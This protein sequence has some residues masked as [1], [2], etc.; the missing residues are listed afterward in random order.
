[1]TIDQYK[2]YALYLNCEKSVMSWID[3]TLSN[4]LEKNQPEQSE[5]EHILDYL[6]QNFFH[7]QFQIPKNSIKLYINNNHQIPN[8]IQSNIEKFLTTETE[9]QQPIDLLLQHK[10]LVRHEIEFD[11]FYTQ[12]DTLKSL[13]TFLNS[14][15]SDIFLPIINNNNT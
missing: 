9:H 8:K 1:M 2:D 13:L 10:I 14:I 4:Y 11:E 3:T 5:V 7:E 15:E 12:D 6:A